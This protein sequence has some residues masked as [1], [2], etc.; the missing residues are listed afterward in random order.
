MSKDVEKYRSDIIGKYVSNKNILSLKV[1]IP[2][3]VTYI[4][5]S[6]EAKL[7]TKYISVL[8]LSFL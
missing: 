6:D 8:N 5:F 1:L 7:H 3:A 4:Y 2:G